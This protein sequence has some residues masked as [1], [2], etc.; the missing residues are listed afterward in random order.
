MLIQPM[1]YSRHSS[2]S[3]DRLPSLSLT[4]GNKVS[5]LLR[6]HDTLETNPTQLLKFMTLDVKHNVPKE[7]LM[8]R[9]D[10]APGVRV[11][12]FPEPIAASKTAADQI[13]K[14]IRACESEGKPCVLGL[15]T[16]STPIALYQELIRMHREE[17]LSFH[18]VV[19]FNLDEYLPMQPASPHSYV[20]FM[21]ENLFDSINIQAENVHIPDGSVP[22]EQ[23]D[24][25]CRDYEDNIRAAG[26]ID[27]QVLGIGRTGH[28]GFNEPGSQPDSSTRRVTLNEVTRQDA[29]PEF[30][31]LENV[32]EYAITM[33]VGTIMQSRQILLLAFGE[34]KAAIVQQAYEGEITSNIPATFLQKHNHVEYL[35]DEPAAMHV[36]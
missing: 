9:N 18:N 27:I 26:G 16:G 14:R 21:K 6:H 25:H 5:I 7:T 20:R 36:G 1:T 31:S 24:Q 17:E 2:H 32:P 3:W 4:W 35:I 19:T 15:A 33:G 23:V 34:S 30:G 28:I 10:S 8:T 12:V 29:T 11:Q 22:P 13:A